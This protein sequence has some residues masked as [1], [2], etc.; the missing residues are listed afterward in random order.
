MKLVRFNLQGTAQRV[1]VL[2]HDLSSREGAVVKTRPIHVLTFVYSTL[3]PQ[4]LPPRA[5]RLPSLCSALEAK[6]D[7]VEHFARETA[8]AFERIP[9][10]GEDGR[11][12]ASFAGG[13]VFVACVEA[14]FGAIYSSLE[15]TNGIVRTLD[16]NVKQGFRAMTKKGFGP[17]QFARWPWLGSFYD[18][19]T[20]LCHFGSPLPSIGESAIVV[21]ITQSHETHRFKRGQKASIPIDEIVAYREGLVEMLDAWALSQLSSLDQE[22]PLF[23]LVFDVEGQRSSERPTLR[24]F[25]ASHL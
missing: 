23:Q 12:L 4:F 25:L 9:Q 22:L 19:R 20:E 8:E 21:D 2:Q 6:L 11:D 13:A 16:P 3:P 14:Y 17:F 18:L 5:G 10:P 7:G 24:E 15:L 1:W